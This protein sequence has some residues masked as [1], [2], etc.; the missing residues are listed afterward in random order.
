M[1]NL[2]PVVDLC[3]EYDSLPTD[4]KKLIDVQQT[5][6]GKLRAMGITVAS[7][8]EV[9]HEAQ[10]RV[11]TQTMALRACHNTPG[12]SQGQYAELLNTH[13]LAWQFGQLYRKGYV[14]RVQRGNTYF[15][16]PA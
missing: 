2:K 7:T 10:R 1:L 14:R 6:V 3:K 5:Y 4:V 13:Q 11:V 12:L 15:Y 16:Y 9:A 8:Q